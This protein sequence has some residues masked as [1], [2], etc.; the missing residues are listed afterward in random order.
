MKENWLNLVENFWEFNEFIED[1][2]LEM[3]GHFLNVD[4]SKGKLYAKRRGSQ[5]G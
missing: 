1:I 4:L 3:I 2:I 5:L